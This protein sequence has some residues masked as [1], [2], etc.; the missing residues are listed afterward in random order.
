MVKV[1]PLHQKQDDG[2]CYHP[3]FSVE[4]LASTVSKNKQTNKKN[5]ERRNGK[6]RKL[7]SLTDYIIVYMDNSI[8]PAD[9]L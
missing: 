2:S 5:K 7:L 1:F 3:F 8:K 9:K 6:G 4:V